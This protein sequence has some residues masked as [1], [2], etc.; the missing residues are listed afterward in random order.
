MDEWFFLMTQKR[1]TQRPQT[2]AMAKRAY[3]MRIRT[4]LPWWL[5]ASEVYGEDP[6]KPS[7]EKT[8]R[9]RGARMRRHVE[10]FAKNE[11]LLWPLPGCLTKSEMAYDDRSYGEEWQ[12]IAERQELKASDYAYRNALRYAIKYGQPWP[13][14]GND[15]E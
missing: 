7:P 2:E 11:G 9:S 3:Y 8:R 5:I 4:R 14:G 13:P 12:V 10:V 1:I 15:D 6:E